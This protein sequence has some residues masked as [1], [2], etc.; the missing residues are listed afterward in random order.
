MDSEEDG[1][2]AILLLAMVEKR[3]P[4]RERRG[5]A[6]AADAQRRRKFG[7]IMSRTI[8]DS[9]F[10]YDC[11]PLAPLVLRMNKRT[12]HHTVCSLATT[13]YFNQQATL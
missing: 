1:E 4:T 13:S 10:A 3:R 12:N 9:W 6:P 11:L 5:G 8:F 2:P 7:L